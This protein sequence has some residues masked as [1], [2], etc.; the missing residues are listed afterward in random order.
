MT[1]DEFIDK[2]AKES[3]M[4]VDE[5]LKDMICLPCGCDEPCCRGFAM[6]QNT[7]RSIETHN[8]FYGVGES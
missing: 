3:G 4:S 5:I 2:Y 6:V 1:A 8:L 7:P